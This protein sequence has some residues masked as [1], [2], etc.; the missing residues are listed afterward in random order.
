MDGLI[1]VSGISSRNNLVI[2][3][4]MQQL[5]LEDNHLIVCHNITST[6][7]GHIS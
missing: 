1:L 5:L 7:T 2:L 6:Q 4:L 3:Y